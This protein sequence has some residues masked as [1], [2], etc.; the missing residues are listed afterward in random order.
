M[1]AK[2]DAHGEQMRANQEEMIAEMKSHWE[3]MKA[4]M[5]TIWEKIKANQQKM[6]TWLEKMGANQ[7]S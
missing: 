2:M 6:D 4:E 3:E 5:K 1:I 7:K